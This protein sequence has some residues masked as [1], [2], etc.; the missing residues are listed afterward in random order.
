MD[1]QYPTL[2]LLFKIV[3]GL[4][5][6]KSLWVGS[7]FNF[8]Y[9]IKYGRLY[10]NWYDSE[11]RNSFKRYIRY[12]FRRDTK[13]Q[14]DKAYIKQPI[15][16]LNMYFEGDEDICDTNKCDFEHRRCSESCKRLA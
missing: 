5:V 16:P 8:Y 1:I 6:F 10:T 9:W 7:R 15:C 3:L 4:Y 11:N 13:E 2:Y 14:I 12:S